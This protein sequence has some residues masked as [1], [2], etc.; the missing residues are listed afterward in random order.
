M[1]ETPNC[2]G[3]LYLFDVFGVTVVISAARPYCNVVTGWSRILLRFLESRF[4]GY[5]ENHGK[6]L[7]AQARQRQEFVIC[8]FTEAKGSRKYF[9]ALLLLHTETESSAILR[10][11]GTGFSE[12]ETIERPKPI[13]TDKSTVENPPKIPEKIQW[14]QPKLVCESRLQNG[15]RMGNCGK[16]RFS[17]DGMKKT[18]RK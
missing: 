17:D 16:R 6:N 3:R 15:L 18:Q 2:S 14:V 10:H 1:A 13:F 5:V 9:G 4:G 8:G 7:F 12:K 11:S